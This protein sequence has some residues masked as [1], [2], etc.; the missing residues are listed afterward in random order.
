MSAIRKEILSYI[1][2]LP[3]SKLEA[4]KPILSILV[5]DTFTVEND[6]TDEE[7]NII[8]NGRKEYKKNSFVS[9]DSLL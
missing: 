3:D 9:L 8:L 4:I 7:K 6:L 2:E 5:N 1:D